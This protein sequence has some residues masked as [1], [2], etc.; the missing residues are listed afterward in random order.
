[1]ALMDMNMSSK[2]SRPRRLLA[3]ATV[4]VCPAC[5]QKRPAGSR[6]G[7]MQHSNT[8]VVGACH[9]VGLLGL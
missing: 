9:C 7:Q 8:K 6:N 4:L 1:M 2:N 3:P 5:N